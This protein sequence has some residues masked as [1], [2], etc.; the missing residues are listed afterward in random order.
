MSRKKHSVEVDSA[1]HVVKGAIV[2]TVG[3]PVTTK[4]SYDNK[5]QGRIAVH[6]EKPDSVSAEDK[7]QIE[8]LS[9][10]KLKEGLDI[11]EENMSRSD[12]ESRY[13]D[14]VNGTPLYDK[15]IPPEKV[16]ELKVVKINDWNVNACPSEHLKKTSDI[17]F[18]ILIKSIN[19]RPQ[20]SELEFIITVGE[21][22]FDLESAEASQT[23]ATEAP[24]ESSSN[25]KKEYVE[26]SGGNV[27][28]VR[29]ELVQV[30]LDLV[31]NKKLTGTQLKEELE[32]EIELRLLIL[33]NLSYSKGFS[34]PLKN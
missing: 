23:Q 16:Q 2:K 1:L 6:W 30:I 13:K 21:G 3:T 11:H 33:R 34:A 28:E 24:K 8:R 31:E 25:S 14:G 19:H 5:T 27:G 20:K 18:P 26:V 9:N 17:P 12:A 32:S 7:K 4:V 22:T 29:D 10:L 15:Q